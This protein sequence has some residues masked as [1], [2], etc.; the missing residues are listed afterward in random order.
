LLAYAFPPFLFCTLSHLRV[1]LMTSPEGY[2]HMPRELITEEGAVTRESTEEFLRK[3]MAEFHRF[4]GRV[5][6]GFAKE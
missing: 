6:A 3:Y 2:I 5:L 1:P 4:I